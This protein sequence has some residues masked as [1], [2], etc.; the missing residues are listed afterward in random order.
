MSA[1]KNCNYT[2]EAEAYERGVHHTM[3]INEVL[4]ERITETARWV[5]WHHALATNAADA[6]T[7]E[8]NADEART[9]SV[10]LAE[11]RRVAIMSNMC[12]WTDLDRMEDKG[13]QLAREMLKKEDATA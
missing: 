6:T 2:P 3:T 5:A 10:V 9:G 7:R 4:E 1:Y 12:H 8:L 13:R 11:L